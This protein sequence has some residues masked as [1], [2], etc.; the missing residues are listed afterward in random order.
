MPFDTNKTA[1]DEIESHCLKCK[2]LTNHMITAMTSNTIAKCQCNTCGA[3]HRYRPP[4]PEEKKAPPST[5]RRRD[6][7]LTKSNQGM[8]SASKNKTPQKRVS[9]GALNFDALSKGRHSSAAIPY[10]MDVTLV[11]GDLINHPTFGL[12][13][14]ISTIP[15]EKAQITFQEQGTKI[16]IC[17]LG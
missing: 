15:P 4:V 10:T 6:G 14:V 9:R 1:G 2:T 13:V 3:I 17:K 11:V 12:G 5:L 8:T 7:I 16:L